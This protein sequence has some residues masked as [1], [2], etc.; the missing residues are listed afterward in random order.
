MCVCF[1]VYFDKTVPFIFHLANTC[2]HCVFVFVKCAFVCLAGESFVFNL[3]ILLRL[4]AFCVCLWHWMLAR[5]CYNWEHMWLSTETHWFIRYIVIRIDDDGRDTTQAAYQSIYSPEDDDDERV[6]NSIWIRAQSQSWFFGVNQITVADDRMHLAAVT[7]HSCIINWFTATLEFGPTP[8]AMSLSQPKMHPF[9]MK[10]KV[11][12]AS[13]AVLRS[14]YACWTK[15]NQNKCTLIFAKH[16][17]FTLWNVRQKRMPQWHCLRTANTIWCSEAA[18]D[19]PNDRLSIG[20]CEPVSGTWTRA[21]HSQQN[22]N[23]IE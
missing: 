21:Q 3:L 11:N 8:P 9:F 2:V 1:F 10:S 12:M 7:S 13:T 18:A 6:S 22:E 5:F 4:D 16:I 15:R 14:E 20:V 17:Y 19:Q 23:K